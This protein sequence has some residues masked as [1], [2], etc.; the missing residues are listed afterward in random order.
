MATS[1][2]QQPTVIAPRK[3]YSTL[4]PNVVKN[5]FALLHNILVKYSLLDKPERICKAD[6][7]GMPLD[8]KPP[9]VVKLVGQDAHTQ[10]SGD[11]TNITV[12]ACASVSGVLLPPQVIFKGKRGMDREMFQGLPS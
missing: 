4:N 3:S 1:E 5:N 11:K 10:T 7:T 8:P 12:V 6:E 2:T 9:K